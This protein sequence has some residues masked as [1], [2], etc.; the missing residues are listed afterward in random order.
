MNQAFAT[1][2]K[3]ITNPL[4]EKLIIKIHLTI[5]KIDSASL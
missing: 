4:P 5:F 1:D 3:N 2:I